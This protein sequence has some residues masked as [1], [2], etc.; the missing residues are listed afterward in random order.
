MTNAEK[1]MTLLEHLTELRQRVIYAILAFVVAFILCYSFAEDIY[2]V[3]MQPLKDIM[4]ET[5]GSH[6]MI[7]TDLTEAFFTYLKVAAFGAFFVAFPF[8]ATQLWIFVAPGLYRNE[9]KAFLPFLIGSPFLFILGTLLVYFMVIPWAWEFLLGFQT[10]GAE[11]PLPI[12][13]EAKVDQYLSLIM[14]LIFAFGISFQLPILLTLLV[15]AG[16]VS[17]DWLAKKRKYAVV[18]VFSFA[19]V[20][21]PPDVISQ[22]GLAVPMLALYEISILIARRIEKKRAQQARETTAEAAQANKTVT[23]IPFEETD[24]NF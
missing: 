17:A 10:T 9:Q 19:A 20:I 23:D 16:L 21:T 22:V 24:F 4:D 12:Q 3:L 6:R 7:F 15:R 5:G 14:K 11:T 2:G 1:S 18:I 8:I 13:L